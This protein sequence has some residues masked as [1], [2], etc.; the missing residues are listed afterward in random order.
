MTRLLGSR[1]RSTLAVIVWAAATV[2]LGACG[3]DGD[4]DASA[5]VT[6]R[7]ADDGYAGRL[8]ADPPM[9]P[10]SVVLRDTHGRAYPLDRVGQVEVVA[11]FFGFT[12]CGD[13]CPTTMADLA[14]A[15]RSLPASLAQRVEVVFVTVDPRRDTRQ[16][17]DRWLDRFDPRFVGLRGPLALVHQAEDSLYAAQSSV[18]R[19]TGG[20]DHHHSGSSE[21]PSRRDGYEVSHSGSVYVF[22]PGGRSLLYT[23][24]TTAPEYAADF[25]RLLES[26]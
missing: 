21:S 19:P 17:L 22:A 11:L 6:M 26:L 12:R 20:D 18:D 25:T 2:A 9:R 10:A 24:G 14:A 23:G 13:V 1:T 4:R 3:T 7:T 16:V 15:R 8:V 5:A